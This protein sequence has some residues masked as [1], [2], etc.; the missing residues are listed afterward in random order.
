V[1]ELTLRAALAGLPLSQIHYYPE[2]GSTNDLAQTLLEQGAPD[3]ALVVADAQTQGRGRLGRHWV[4]T[5][6]AA[7]AFSLTLRPTSREQGSLALFAP[8]AGLAVCQALVE[9]YALPAE[10][11]WP[12]D[13][14]LNRRKT[15]GVLVE[16]AWLGS[17]LQGV[18]AGIGV[19][20]APSAVPPDSAVLFPATCIEQA[21]GKPVDRLDL[22][23]AIVR[24][25]VTL[26][27]Q[28]GTP[29]FMR[30]WLER[31]AFRGEEVQVDLLSPGQSL[32]G[33]VMGIDLDGSLRL[34]TQGGKEV[35][36]AAGDVHLRPLASG[37]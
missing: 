6:G 4:T 16:A 32:V 15:C 12:N 8:L 28:L 19:N 1:D 36:V 14:L 24:Q 22:L 13:V 34:V 33:H 31:L 23:A 2:V 29:A 26:R 3:G 7:L 30:L 10:V 37:N 35:S 20:I 11:K 27:G 5:P 18:V 9:D 21:L 17:R 25:F